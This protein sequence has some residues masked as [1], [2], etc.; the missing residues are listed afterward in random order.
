MK[1]L[2]KWRIGGALLLLLLVTLPIFE[3]RAESNAGSD[4]KLNPDSINNKKE[5]HTTLSDLYGISVFSDEFIQKES[6]YKEQETEKQQEIFNAVLEKGES[7]QNYENIVQAVL[8]ADDAKIIKQDYSEVNSRKH[9]V[10]FWLY[11]AFG[12]IALFGI[13]IL[14]GETFR[15]KRTREYEDNLDDYYLEGE[16]LLSYSSAAE[17]KN[18]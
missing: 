5:D 13:V 16:S 9:T 1:V 11:F 3:V 4:I 7:K 10:L 17:S 12:G 14:L 15:Q 18:L 8:Q 2:H 6:Q